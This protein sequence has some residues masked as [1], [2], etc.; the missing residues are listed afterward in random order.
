MSNID[1]IKM[2]NEKLSTRS[3]VVFLTGGAGVGK[4]TLVRSFEESSDKNITKL[5]TTGAAALLLGGNTIESALQ[6][7]PHISNPVH[8]ILEI[9]RF[10]KQKAI[11]NTDIIMIDEASMLRPDKLDYIDYALRL[12]CNS[13]EPFAGKCLLLVGDLFQ[14]PPVVTASS[15]LPNGYITPFFFG[16]NVLKQVEFSTI[17]L[18]K[19]YRQSDSRFIDALNTVRLGE[20]TQYH[21]D[22]LNLK[23][24]DSAPIDAVTLA[25]YNDAISKLNGTKL[26]DIEGDIFQLIAEVDGKISP[27][28]FIVDKE[29]NLKIGARVVITRNS[30]NGSYVNGSLGVVMDI[31]I[32]GPIIV[33]LDTGNEVEIHKEV[34]QKTESTFS[35][36]YQR[37]E[38][39]VIGTIKQFPL[40]LA[41]GISIHKSQ[42]AT[43][44]KAH[45]DLGRGAFAAGQLYVALSRLRS[46][47]GLTLARPIQLTDIIVDQRIKDFFKQSKII[48]L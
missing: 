19:V 9:K 6:I 21:L 17:E 7:P 43:Y 44:D 3:A 36:Y 47:D 10:E 11:I 5:A 20:A 37:N 30:N 16:A 27:N 28:D 23:V 39:K 35:V 15:G 32:D 25:P 18:T 29:L 24:V 22:Y 34:W 8:D 46:Y 38:Q 33:K 42:G 14:L 26:A 2:L 12:N 48:R 31:E 4:T 41:W 13:Q 1:L 40:K 45:I